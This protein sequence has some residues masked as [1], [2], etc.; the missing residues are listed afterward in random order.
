MTGKTRL[1]IVEDEP[2]MMRVLGDF[3]SSEGYEVLKAA[4][5]EQGLALALS[6]RPDLILLDIMLPRK[7]GYDLCRELRAKGHVTPIVIITGKG[8]EADKV[9]GLELGAD[10][11]LTKPFGLPELNARVRAVLRRSGAG[12]QG[13]LERY[14]IDGKEVDFKGH[15]LHAKGRTVALSGTE[16]ALLAFMILHRGEAL[17]R[18]RI[19]DE[20]WG[21]ESFPT[22]RT[23]DMHI[24]K[25]RKKLE[26]NPRKPRH[27]LTVHG[28]GYKFVD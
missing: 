24:V 20:V 27:L 8:E 2:K 13:G 11:Y 26:R 16:A 22:T 21:Y 14:V 23:V 19:L 12:R 9:L 25:L 15:E 18:D 10:D 6:H 17:S 5:G 3:L 4:D 7:S 28:V 1:L